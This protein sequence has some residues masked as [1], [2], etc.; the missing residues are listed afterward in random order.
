MKKILVPIIIMVF[1]VY[2]TAQLR[3]I[4]D[5]TSE[6]QRSQ[7]A[8]KHYQDLYKVA[9][10]YDDMGDILEVFMS[11]MIEESNNNQDTN[12]R[13]G[14][15][16]LG[17]DETEGYKFAI[18]RFKNLYDYAHSVGITDIYHVVQAYHF[19]YYK[20]RQVIPVDES[21]CKDYLNWVINKYGPTIRYSQTLA[22]SYISYATWQVYNKKRN[23]IIEEYVSANWYRIEPQPDPPYDKDGNLRDWYSESDLRADAGTYADSIWHYGDVHYGRKEYAYSIMS[24][25]RYNYVY[26]G[27][28]DLGNLGEIDTSD[29]VTIAD[30]YMNIPY[31]SPNSTPP[32]TFDCSSFTRYVYGKCGISIN[33]QAYTQYNQATRFYDINLAQP[34]D[35]IFFEGERKDGQK[36]P[37]EDGRNIIHV[38]IYLGSGRFIHASSGAGKVVKSNLSSSYYQTHFAAFGRIGR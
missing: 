34:G 15:G 11:I 1:L 8:R 6:V 31:K 20:E 38:G 19:L 12:D 24:R 4:V 9:S 3:L 28:I 7:Y 18:E 35:L 36:R 29:I 30:S 17:T 2:I 10:T 21:F 33:A 22:S 13:L 37:A 14:A 26:E 25:T 5:D 32:S 16:Y 27:E 23:M